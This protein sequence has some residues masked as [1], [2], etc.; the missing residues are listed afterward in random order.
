MV[1]RKCVARKLEDVGGRRE[2]VSS[3]EL[4]DS[5]WVPVDSC[6]VE[7]VSGRSDLAWGP[8]A[9]GSQGRCDCCD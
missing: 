5:S 6:E 3:R 2:L 7:G 8:E 4:G 1:R 9:M